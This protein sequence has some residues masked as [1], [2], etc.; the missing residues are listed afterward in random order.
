MLAK[1][2]D[3]LALSDRTHDAALTPDDPGGLSH[4]ERA[5]FAC[6]IARLNDDSGFERHFEQLMD[7]ADADD[8]V[9]RL[10]E[11]W[12]DGGGDAR[13]RAL[14]RHVDLVAHDPKSA[15]KNDIELLKQAGISDAD[16]V[17]LS[18]LIAFVSYQIRVVAGLKL[19]RAST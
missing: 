17:R 16:I 19:M 14:I 2:A 12:F 13:T 6:R 3:I 9:R 10:A 1:R 4:A 7:D 8:S 5:A 11:A 15:T 18:E